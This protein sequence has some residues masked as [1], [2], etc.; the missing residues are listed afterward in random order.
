MVQRSL[1]RLRKF[2]DLVWILILFAGGWV[3]AAMYVQV[4]TQ[5]HSYHQ[6]EFAPAVYLACGQGFRVAAA[7]PSGPLGRF[8]NMETDTLDCAQVP[9]SLKERER[10]PASVLQSQHLIR[11]VGLTWMLTGVSW[12]A[13][14]PLS[15]LF[16]GIT[17]VLAFGVFRLGIGRIVSGLLAS[18]LAISALQLDH[19]LY[20][21]DFARAPFFLAVLA[22]AGALVKMPWQT[23]RNITLAAA[24]GLALGLGL[25]FRLDLAV[26][27]PVVPCTLL[28][29]TPAPF[30]EEMAGR[31][32]ALLANAVMVLGFGGMVLI[33]APHG[34]IQRLPVFPAMVQPF[35]R[36]ADLESSPVHRAESLPGDAYALAMVNS[37]AQRVHGQ[38]PPI[39]AETPEYDRYSREMV[40]WMVRNFPADVVTA[41]WG[42]LQTVVSL[43]L[44]YQG[45]RSSSSLGV[46]L[47]WAEWK[48]A[49]YRQAPYLPAA[50][51][52]ATVA[53]L[54]AH[55]LRWG[56]F[57]S[58]VLLYFGTVPLLQFHSGDV[59]HLE[60]LIWWAFGFW[61]Q[62]LIVIMQEA[63][64]P[65][66][67]KWNEQVSGTIQ[68]GS[69]WL[70]GAASLFAFSVY[71]LRWVQAT[72]A[73]P[74]LETFATAALDPLQVKVRSGKD[75]RGRATLRFQ[76]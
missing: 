67:F 5:D 44:A 66:F 12:P 4:H 34:E 32:G 19:L 40:F 70:L 3:W 11:L 45:R 64:N 13:L 29:L 30:R 63:K 9:R 7:A 8:L 61:V 20:L 56:V 53:A 54:G 17:L 2:P 23:Q 14:A 38:S 75:S 22:T 35:D 68:R 65:A 27:L 15:G 55:A 71:P 33:G 60:I 36:F 58:L 76:P 18:G 41:D 48:N 24:A 28:F 39:E 59:F 25:G 73:A 1:N 49:L 31:M 26:C 21:R 6:Q 69:W 57:A 47:R 62:R 37:Y 10:W 43:P 16:F 46:V 72:Q 51:V 74:L 52:L 42:S 50:L